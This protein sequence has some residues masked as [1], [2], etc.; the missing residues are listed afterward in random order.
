[1][2][3]NAQCIA[4]V[5]IVPQPSGPVCKGDVVVLKAVPTNGGANPAY[6]WVF[7]GDTL[8]NDSIYTNTYG[9][10]KTIGVY[11]VGS[12]TCTPDTVFTSYT[13]DVVN[14]NVIP[15]IPASVCNQTSVD[16]QISS[17]SGGQDPYTYN[18]DGE[19]VGSQTTFNDLSLGS[20]VLIITDD[21]GCSDTTTIDVTPFPCPKPVPSKAFTPNG[22]GINDGFYILNIQFYPN[23]KVYIFDRWGQRV[24]YKEGYTNTDP[25]DAKYMDASMP[26]SAYF[27][28]IE[29]GEEDAN[30]EEII[31]RGATS[32]IR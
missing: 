25:W 28:I 24:F 14:I 29:T 26:V 3:G 23:N 20:H 30:G 15:F 18:I 5:T 9:T 8:H 21:N 4:D 1:M 10:D 22:D 2:F 27:Y 13:I 11:M 16:V 32:V 7:N 6:Y 19:D 12:D 17:T 31:L